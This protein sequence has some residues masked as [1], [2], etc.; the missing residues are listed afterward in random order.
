MIKEGVGREHVP[1]S[2][3]FIESLNESADLNPRVGIG[4]IRHAELGEGLGI[5][6]TKFQI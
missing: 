3:K 5:H 4:R 6:K 1:G 2:K